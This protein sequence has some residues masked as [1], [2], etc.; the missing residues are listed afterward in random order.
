MKRKLEK[1]VIHWLRLQREG[2]DEAAAETAL[3]NAFSLMPY[4]AVPSDFSARV[5]AQLGI[6]APL[7]S[8]PVWRP[9]LV[10]RW[11]L[12][13][14]L[15][16]G[17]WLTWFLPEIFPSLLALLNPSR[18]ADLGV[19]TFVT[20][21]QSFGEGLVVWGA[22]ADISS[23]LAEVLATPQSLAVL[24]SAVLVSILAFRTLHGLIA[25]ERSSRYVGSV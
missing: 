4:G 21:A 11:V 2:R 18:L 15:F 3:R 13:S 6:R 12:C 7:A 22:L 20:A 24:A 16:I 14:C 5:L 1:A 23:K 25:S 10:L 19:G 17:A 8:V 9:N